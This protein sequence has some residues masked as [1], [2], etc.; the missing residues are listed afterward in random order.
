MR[1]GKTSS[2]VALAVLS[3]GGFA[4]PVTLLELGTPVQLDAPGLPE[5][6]VV[7]DATGDGKPDL[8]VVPSRASSV[9]IHPGNGDGTFGPAIHVDTAPGLPTFH[10]TGVRAARLN[11]DAAYDLVI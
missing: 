10:A 5:C 8:V 4:E 9:T 3:G 1:I 2:L 7:A 6:A 11:G